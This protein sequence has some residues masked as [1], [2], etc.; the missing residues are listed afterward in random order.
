[1]E[2]NSGKDKGKCMT[3]PVEAED[4]CVHN[5]IKVTCTSAKCVCCDKDR[6]EHEPCPNGQMDCCDP[7][8]CVDGKCTKPKPSE[9]PTTEPTVEPTAEPSTP[10][11]SGI[12]APPVSTTTPPVE[13]PGPSPSEEPTM[14]PATHS[15]SSTSTPPVSSTPPNSTPTPPINTVPPLFT[16]N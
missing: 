5:G 13:P 11:P 10:F 8:E 7:F 3:W 15:P 9:A 1:M 2:T 4:N 6:F 16:R 14:E 12:R